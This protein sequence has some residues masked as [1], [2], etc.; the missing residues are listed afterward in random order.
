MLCDTP[1]TRRRSSMD[2]IR[3]AAAA[4]TRSLSGTPGSGRPPSVRETE[5]SRLARQFLHHRG[6]QLASPGPRTLAEVEHHPTA[7][8]PHVPPTGSSVSPVHETTDRTGRQHHEQTARL[9]QHHADGTGAGVQFHDPLDDGDVDAATARPRRIGS[10][11]ARALFGG[12]GSGGPGPDATHN[13]NHALSVSAADERGDDADSSGDESDNNILPDGDPFNDSQSSFDADVSDEEEDDSAVPSTWLRTR[14]TGSSASGG[15]TPVVSP[16]HRM[17]HPAGLLMVPGG[18]ARG[19]ASVVRAQSLEDSAVSLLLAMYDD[20]D[21]SCVSDLDFS[22]LAHDGSDVDSAPGTPFSPDATSP[23]RAADL[24]STITIL[25]IL[26]EVAEMCTVALAHTSGAPEVPRP[27]MR[28]PGARDAVLE[29][30]VS[31]VWAMLLSCRNPKVAFFA[32]MFLAR[33]TLPR[34]ADAGLPPPVHPHHARAAVLS[35][36]LSTAR[37]LLSEDNL[38]AR[39]ESWTFETACGTHATPPVPTS[40]AGATA[41]PCYYEVKL[42]GD[43]PVHVG[44]GVDAVSTIPF[45]PE[46]MQGV[47]D[48]TGTF[49]YD[50]TYLYLD[51]DTVGVELEGDGNTDVSV[52]PQWCRGDVVACLLDTSDGLARFFV[53]GERLKEVELRVPSGTCA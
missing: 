23:R 19:V 35:Y 25:R 46:G 33:T 12:A 29:A 1:L 36:A 16:G 50:G 6:M 2:V 30:A 31:T 17:H 40:A 8:S 11:S 15:V 44:W 38:T 53:N 9:P 20:N 22:T 41:C 52:S 13:D 5:S 4:R 18:R 43:G 49:A 10:H 24:K 14:S 26:K 7:A 47:G 51:G 34:N 3:T 21:A 27:G 37:V 42:L 45:D 32:S 28:C 48:V 39:N